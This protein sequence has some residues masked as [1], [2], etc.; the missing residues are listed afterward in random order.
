MSLLALPP[1]KLRRTID[2][3]SLKIK[4]SQ[5]LEAEDVI[6]LPGQPRA[7]KSLEFGLRIELPGYNIVVTGVPGTGR[8]TL[9][10]SVAKKWAAEKKN[11]GD[12][13]YVYNFEKPFNPLYLK[14]KPGEGKV[15]AQSMETFIENAKSNLRSAFE[16]EEY[17]A[18]KDALEQELREKQ[19]REIERLQQMA[20]ER[21]LSLMRTP[22]GLVFVPLK[23]GKALTPEEF[24]SLPAEEREVFEQH[25]E[26]MQK[27]AQRFFQKIPRWQ[28]E[29]REKIKQLNQEVAKF[30]LKHLLDELKEKF[31]QN[32]QVLAYL[33]KVEAD[34]VKNIALFFLEEQK[35]A[36]LQEEMPVPLKSEESKN[37][38][39]FR[40]YLV[41]VLVDN[42]H[43][44]HAPV[45]YEDNPSLGNLVGKIEHIQQMG[46]LVT[47]FHLLK[48]GALHKANGGV[49]ILDLEQLLLNP[50]SFEALK[51]CLKSA[52]IRIENL[53]EKFSLIS[54]VSLE[55]EPIPLEVKIILIAPP[56]LF[57]LLKMYDPDFIKLFKII[58]DF[59]E[60]LPF[61]A[62]N[63]NYYLKLIASI[64]KKNNLLP[65]KVEAIAK[66]MEYALRVV[67]DKEKISAEIR[68]VS[69]LVSESSFLAK[70]K[71]KEEVEKE[72]VLEAIEFREFRVNRHQEK[73]LEAIL[74][75]II[76]IETEGEAIGQIN[77]LSVISLGD[78]SFGRPSKITANV[79]LGEGEV[80]DIEREVKLGG[81]IHSK[82]V[83]ILSSFLG[84]RYAK[85]NPLSLK[86]TLVFEQSYSGVEG[87][88]ASAAELLALLS[89][90]AEV[91]LKQGLAITGSVDQKG[92]IQPIGGVNEKIEG[93]FTLC[94][95]R[96][97]TGDQGVV[98]P[99]A[100]VKH[101]MLKEEVV[102]A[103]KEG[104]FKVYAIESID[105]A[106][107]L[108]TGLPAGESIEGEG[109][110]RG[111][112][113]ALVQEKLE[114]F[115]QRRKELARQ[116]Q[117]KEGDGKED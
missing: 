100:N 95:K 48:P 117:G 15:L 25:L 112:F 72:D 44:S 69:D 29:V 83:M 6:L 104:K 99:R 98:I 9:V 78:F 70:S 96:G 84:A 22:Q 17:Q 89:A 66:V 110:A 7:C 94:K 47:D 79:R 108:F 13:C 37:S 114:F 63:I 5:E 86:A 36:A 58:A 40:R 33:E 61:D 64:I 73:V 101:L 28:Q 67:E 93:F 11:P 10:K 106:I 75:D 52:Q 8:H 30:T 91:P 51:R 107:E 35:K 85:T 82:G 57:Y 31:A 45:I 27:E 4:S 34:M 1:E 2:P 102:E 65:F 76:F 16:S 109:F 23:E 105:E 43:L 87:D 38:S 32:K 81:P 49:L 62:E 56:Y 21:S 24:E 97:F 71:N 60:S 68:K 74:R 41:N 26:E 77:G 92:R 42:S 54:T 46:F 3:A 18:Q 14:L 80:V 88:S 116:L 20:A 113:N 19:Q 53:A 50:G 39:F 103:V 90:I 12:W 59:D 55:P 115:A 111:S